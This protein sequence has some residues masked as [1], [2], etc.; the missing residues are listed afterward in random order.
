M[1]IRG[2]NGLTRSRDS[3]SLPIIT[4][5]IVV[6]VPL[7]AFAVIVPNLLARPN[8]Y[9]E[10]TAPDLYEYQ[11]ERRVEVWLS[12]DGFNPATQVLSYNF[13][14]RPT[15][16]V[17]GLPVNNTLMVPPGTDIRLMYSN[18]GPDTEVV[19]QG[20][21]VYQGLNGRVTAT[22]FPDSDLGT[23]PFDAYQGTILIRG[24]IEQSGTEA[25]AIVAGD[26]QE[27]R[28]ATEALWGPAQFEYRYPGNTTPPDT[29]ELWIAR[30]ARLS[31]IDPSVEPMDQIQI[32]DDVVKGFYLLNVALV[33][34][35]VTQVIA[36]SLG[37]L[38]CILAAIGL[39]LFMATLLGHRP[40]SLA[41]LV[42]INSLL[43]TT[44]IARTA[45]PGAPPIGVDLDLRTYFP[46]LIVLAGSSIGTSC[47]WIARRSA[48]SGRVAEPFDEPRP[49]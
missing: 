32:Q 23:Y 40:P 17:V 25:T 11:E 22:P 45:M 2:W 42:W 37:V 9:T 12:V 38:F 27:I 3:R 44:I 46:A 10:T 19:L 29:F 6:L 7:I 43:F 16:P 21:N 47:L 39:I 14:L 31:L 33:R 4:V 1:R 8:A 24:A 18:F 28:D 34:D 13:N 5:L 48:I 41:A 35:A 15:F 49:L 36:I 30:V 26:S 20:G